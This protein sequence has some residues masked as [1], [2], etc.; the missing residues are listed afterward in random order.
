MATCVII[1]V[2][3]FRKIKTAASINMAVSFLELE[4]ASEFDSTFKRQKKFTEQYFFCVF[5]YLFFLQI[6]R[7][8]VSWTF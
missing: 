5:F 3:L 4:K 1:T 7:A 2:I 6:Y 8:D